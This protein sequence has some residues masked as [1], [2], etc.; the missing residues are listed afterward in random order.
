MRTER[1]K[2]KF[3]QIRD[4]RMFHGSNKSYHWY[5]V[6]EKTRDNKKVMSFIK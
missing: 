5:S 6:K 2:M 3:C 1:K 4:D